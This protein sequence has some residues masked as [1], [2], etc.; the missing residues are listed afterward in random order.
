MRKDWRATQ[1]NPQLDR[2]LM[3]VLCHRFREQYRF[4]G[5]YEIT[6]YIVEDI[7]KIVDQYHRPLSEVKKGQM[8]WNG[9]AIDQGRK[10]GPGLPM[11]DTKLIPIIL[12]MVSGEDIKRL[13]DGVPPREVRKDAIE[14]MHKEAE[15]Q[16]A[17]LNNIEVGL[18]LKF[19]QSTV[20]K[21]QKEREK[22]KG[23]QLPNRG[24]VHDL[25]RG[26]THKGD[27]LR[28]K[29][30]HYYQPEISR[31]TN[32]SGEAVDDYLRDYNRVKLLRD[33]HSAEDIS[34][35]TRMSLS[36]VKVYLELIGELEGEDENDGKNN[37]DRGGKTLSG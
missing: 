24:K 12:T 25:S 28:L 11:K 30:R 29:L 21:Y 3:N 2:T 20:N 36:L 18:I 1:Y 14:R 8:V 34:F 13:R 19:D 37:Q 9:V 6:Q 35:V 33:D 26:V 7:L 10:P 16:G 15:K 22:E 23:I 31:R 27:I 32:H 5:G 4:L 17:T